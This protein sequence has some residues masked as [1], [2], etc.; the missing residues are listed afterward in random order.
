MRLVWFRNDL[1]LADNPALRHACAGKSRSRRSSSSRR[2][3]G[4]STLAPARQRFI[5]AQ[6]DALGRELAALGIPLHLLRVETFAE[7][8]AVLADLPRARGER[9]LCQPGHRDRRAAP[10]PDG[11]AALAEQEI[12]SHWFNGCCVLPPGRVL[13]GSGRCSRCSPLQ[14]RLAKALEEDGF[15]IH[16]APAPRGAPIP[17]LPLAERPFVDAALGS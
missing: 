17:W 9:A 1:R 16:R 5:L 2:P 7:V 4:G 15:V 13:T 14:P 3:S 10:R 11:H 8:P 6:L 12:G